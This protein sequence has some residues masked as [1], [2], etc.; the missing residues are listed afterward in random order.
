M[1]EI[2]ISQPRITS[3]LEDI[4][5]GKLKLP[6]FQRDYNW[7]PS[8]VIKLM[9]S[10]QKNHPSG[11]LLFLKVNSQQQVITER[12]FEAAPNS[13]VST[14]Y[15]VLDGQQR[16]TSCYY[17]FYNKGP[18]SYY[19]DLKKIFELYKSN[20]LK[21]AD[22]DENKIIKVQKHID[23][24]DGELNNHLFPM[25]CFSSRTEFKST[26]SKYK[27]II[28]D[29]ESDFYYFIDEQFELYCNSFFDYQFPIVELPENLSLDAVCKVFQTINT[30]GLK[31][32]AFDICVAKFMRYG[33]N[34]KVKLNDAADLYPNIKIISKKDNTIILQTIALLNNISPK[35]NLLADNLT[36]TSFRKWDKAI[37]GLNEAIDLLNKMGVGCDKSLD[38][39][40]YQP[41]I[42]L[43]G[44]VLP[45]VDYWEG[46]LQKQSQIYDKLKKFFYFTSLSSRY[47]EGT[48][49]K[50]KEDFGLLC[51]WILEDE[52]PNYM[53][54]GI[55]WNREKMKVAPKGSAMG[56]IILCLIN[57][58]TPKDF[59][60][61][62][63][64][65]IGND[66]ESSDIH[67]IFPK[68]AYPSIPKNMINSVF[69]MTFITSST[70][71]N[72]KDKTTNLY[73]NDIMQRM[74][75]TETTLTSKLEQHFI[76]SEAY[77]AM[78]N[79]D[80]SSFLNCREE[81]IRIYLE[82]NVGL[83]VNVINS[84]IDET[85][86]E[87]AFFDSEE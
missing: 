46:D 13:E 63:K 84:N 37:K 61:D 44:A 50:M 83:T 58:N 49:N 76:Y 12:Q 82:K 70:N 56:K 19:L 36:D 6:D 79:Q 2:K 33:I 3:L 72:I 54:H 38:L 11:S 24:P 27:R 4:E 51:K 78:K 9:D 1:E 55:D 15:L 23:I 86:Y 45:D 32:S 67:H 35:M 5:I 52:I 68:A 73:I 25:G 77:E 74:G 41:Y 40:P 65:G 21:N 66:R 60:N 48:D 31:L 59:Y 18:K 8:K 39:L 47:T 7:S 75:I 10:I 29:K 16:L 43:F 14:E 71:R 62:S 22:L 81:S 26:L 28:T 42:A 30:T 64:V 17:V 85:E 34:L 57:S 69:N 80:Y 87:E 53:I 20:E